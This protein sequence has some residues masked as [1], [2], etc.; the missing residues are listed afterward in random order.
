MAGYDKRTFCQ[1]QGDARRAMIFILFKIE[2][3][4]YA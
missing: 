1:G 2:A 4:C 3:V